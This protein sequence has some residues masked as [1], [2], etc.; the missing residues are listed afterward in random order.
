MWTRIKHWFGW[1]NDRPP[2][3]V[4]IPDDPLES[5]RLRRDTRAFYMGLEMKSRDILDSWYE[6]RR[7]QNWERTRGN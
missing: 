5:V 3:L 7:R 6:S 1:S 2:K 4:T